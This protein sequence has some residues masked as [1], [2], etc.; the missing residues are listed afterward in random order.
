MIKILSREECL[1]VSDG[2]L[3][4]VNMQHIFEAATD[5]RLTDDLF[6]GPGVHLCLDGR[7]ARL[8]LQRAFGTQYALAVGNELV[9]RLLES[10][11]GHRI[12][13]IG[14]DQSTMTI[15]RSMYPDVHIMHDDRRVGDATADVV[16]PL[17]SYIDEAATS[18]V[19]AI[20]LAL[21]V[22][23]QEHLAAALYQRGCRVPIY[24]IGGSF[25]MI[26]GIYPRA[27]AWVQRIGFEGLWRLIRQP[28]SLRLRRL[29]NS[30]IWFARLWGRPSRVRSILGIEVCTSVD[31]SAA[32]AAALSSKYHNT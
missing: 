10:S 8:L 28:T 29:L 2:Y 26:A 5:G 12:V 9:A 16:G 25:E 17:H 6:R 19:R 13:V 23:K 21:G 31:S 1:S 11:S 24:C 22:P 32:D 20:C 27:P 18:G 30:Y 7:G 3:V 4:T 15:I 14:T